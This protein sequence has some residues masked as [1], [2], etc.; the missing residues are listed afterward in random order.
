MALQQ[1]QSISLNATSACHAHLPTY[2]KR[3][4]CRAKPGIFVIKTYAMSK[5]RDPPHLKNQTKT[6]MI[7]VAQKYWSYG[8]SLW[9][10]FPAHR[11]CS[12]RCLTFTPQF[13]SRH[14]TFDIFDLQSFWTCLNCHE[15]RHALLSQTHVVALCCPKHMSKTCHMC[16]K[17]GHAKISG[18]GC[19]CAKYFPWHNVFRHCSA[20]FAINTFERCKKIMKPQ[21]E[22][23]IVCL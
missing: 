12:R 1:H 11:K 2:S 23:F 20:V 5:S 10:G 8:P 17:H 19:L 15:C 14:F 3:E 13:V 9:Q 7:V 6:W 4:H 16:T 22:T 21:Y 18:A